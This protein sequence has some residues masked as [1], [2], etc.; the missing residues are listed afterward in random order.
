MWGVGNPNPW[1]FGAARPG[2]NKYGD[3][4]IALD[5]NSGDLKW[6]HQ[7]LPHDVWDYD[8]TTIPIVFDME[9]GDETRRVVSLDHKTGWTYVIDVET[10]RLLERSEAWAK[11]EHEWDQTFLSLPPLGK[12]NAGNMWPSVWGGTEW[13][14]DAYS[15]TTGL[16]Y[17][18]V[19]NAPTAMWRADNWSYNEENPKKAVG[20][21]TQKVKGGDHSAEVAAMN[22]D[23]GDVVWTHTLEHVKSN[24][25]AARLYAGGTTATA[26]NVVFHGS[27]SG[28]L[29]AL[30]AESGELLWESKTDRRIFT[31]PVVWE[32]PAE[33]TAY[34]SVFADEKFYTYSLS[35][36]EGTQ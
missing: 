12:E 32:D 22:P 24:W 17:I 8:A 14:P 15:P 2:P 19:N 3:S 34:V 26:G 27:S 18:G 25:P 29:K 35:T 7:I 4:V 9:V 21:G 30:S 20:G 11:Q 6:D 28:Y 5:V 13:P 36:S 33:D 16:R 10:G 23:S 31:S 1:F